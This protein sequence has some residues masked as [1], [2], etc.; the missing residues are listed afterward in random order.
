MVA[1]VQR[2]GFAFEF[3]SRWSHF[4]SASLISSS[5]V[6][7]HFIVKWTLQVMKCLKIVCWGEAAARPELLLKST[8]GEAEA[9]LQ[10][11]QECQ[12]ETA[13]QLSRKR[14][15]LVHYRNRSAS[16]FERN[17]GYLNF[18]SATETLIHRVTWGILGYGTGLDIPR[19]WNQM[20]VGT[21]R[22]LWF[23][24]DLLCAML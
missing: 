14:W 15:K 9:G 12:T 11:Q 22:L 16:I 19:M 3:V 5:L 6:C 2:E 20:V 7:A 8:N 23:L 10:L 21:A 4:E 18:C 24:Q 13:L 1:G 17:I